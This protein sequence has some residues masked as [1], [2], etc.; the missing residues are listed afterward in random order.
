M[1]TSASETCGNLL[2]QIRASNLNFVLHETPYSAQICLRK[3]F[4]KDANGPSNA[5]SSTL[6]LKTSQLEEGIGALQNENNELKTKL[7]QSELDVSDYRDTVAILEEKVE[8]AEAN[9]YKFITTNKNAEKD[10]NEEIK[11]LKG[12]IKNSTDELQNNK[13]QMNQINKLVK[14]KE[15]EN[16]NLENKVENQ[17]ETIRSLKE[18]C[19]FLNSE[20]RILEKELKSCR[21]KSKNIKNVGKQVPEKLAEVDPPGKEIEASIPPPKIDTELDQLDEQNLVE[22][23]IDLL[24]ADSNRTSDLNSNPTPTVDI[25]C[26]VCSKTF[27]SAPELSDHRR[28]NH[29]DM[30][31]TCKLCDQTYQTDEDLCNHRKDKSHYSLSK[32]ISDQFMLEVGTLCKECSVIQTPEETFYE[33][34]DND[35]HYESFE[36]IWNNLKEKTRET[37]AIE[38]YKN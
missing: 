21:K 26:V 34:C 32:A 1:V 13:K 24:S 12:V 33:F 9:L 35:D 4:I 19:N 27:T 20:K 7:E 17:T 5:V 14:S 2:L 18:T 6:S 37:E 31:Y 8:K 11:L 16:Y 15:K 29:P 23:K 25:P 10:K 22:D 28:K 36:K 38:I 3:R 30:K